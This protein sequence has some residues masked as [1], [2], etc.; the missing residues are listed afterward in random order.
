MRLNKSPGFDE[1]SF[2]VIKKCFLSLHKSLFNLFNAFITKLNFS[3]YVKT[4][5]SYSIT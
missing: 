2:N 4:C 1:V 5:S 3:R